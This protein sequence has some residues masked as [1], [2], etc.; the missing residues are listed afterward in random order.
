M[1]RYALLVVLVSIAASS[2]GFFNKQLSVEDVYTR[3]SGIEEIQNP[4][5]RDF[6]L[7]DLENAPVAVTDA[8]VKEIRASSIYGYDYCILVEVD[9]PSETIEC[10][11]YSGKNKTIAKLEPGVTRIDAVGDFSRLTY[12]LRQKPQ[13]EIVDAKITPLQQ[14]DGFFKKTF[15]KIGKGFLAIL[16]PYGGKNDDASPSE[17]RP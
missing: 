7:N 3:N 12:T 15:R 11:I 17:A 2:C 10:H 5:T 4:A 14:K 16:P 13:I 8:L 6:A 9:S 1:K